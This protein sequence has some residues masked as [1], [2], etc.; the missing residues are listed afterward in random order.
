M[1][2]QFHSGMANLPEGVVAWWEAAADNM[3]L[4]PWWIASVIEASLDPS[5][6]VALGLLSG[7]DDAPLALLSCRFTTAKRH[8]KLLSLTGI[9]SCLFRP[10]LGD[11]GERPRIARSLGQSIARALSPNDIVH[12]DAVDADWA[13]MTDFEAGLAEGGFTTARYAHFGNW[14]QALAD[15]SFSDYLASRDG[16]LREIL[17]RKQRVADRRGAEFV[18]VRDESELASHWAAYDAVYRSSGKSPEPYPDFQASL[19]RHA[20]RH[21]ALRLGILRL[22]DVPVAVQLWI[23]WRG[24]ATVLKLAHDEAHHDL[25]PGSLLTIYMI[26]NLMEQDHIDAIDFGRGDDPYKRRWVAERRAR[27]GLIAANP[28]TPHGALLLAR[29]AAG[30]WL[31]ALKGRP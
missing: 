12:F 13:E 1:P 31:R 2:F 10:V 14:H 25:S 30:Q 24:T 19:A 26:K 11:N 5:D 17:R 6:T 21:G 20:A 28:R 3:F 4:T 9:Y 8:R 18:I 15:Q 23:V 7:T 27:I 16:A 29:Q 22:G